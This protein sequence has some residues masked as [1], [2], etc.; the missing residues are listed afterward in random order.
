MLELMALGKAIYVL[1]Q[2]DAENKLALQIFKEGGILGIGTPIKAP[3]A[4]LINVV[5]D[6][7]RKMIDGFG[8]KRLMRH[9]EVIMQ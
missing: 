6:K 1:P 5:G 4:E 3:S 8:T 2:S 7:A 9:I